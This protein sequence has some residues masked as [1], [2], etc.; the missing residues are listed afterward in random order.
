MPDASVTA[1]STRATSPR[2]TTGAPA[3]GA[4]CTFTS[5]TMSGSLVSVPTSARWPSPDT[6]CA[7]RWGAG[8]ATFASSSPSVHATAPATPTTNR[9]RT[10]RLV[11][12]VPSRY[13]VPIERRDAHG[14]VELRDAAVE[15]HRR[16]PDHAVTGFDFQDAPGDR[17]AD[18]RVA[19][20]QALD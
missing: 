6:I 15:R 9:S 12:I 14:P 18:D 3:I 4:P 2:N 20:R 11:G 16:G 7:V 5:L 8:G 19:V 1:E 10:I 17:E 13:G